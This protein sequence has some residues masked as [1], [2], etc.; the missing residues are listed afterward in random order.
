MS[1]NKP[2]LLISPP[3]MSLMKFLSRSKA[4]I[5]RSANYVEQI[6][7]DSIDQWQNVS[8]ILVWNPTAED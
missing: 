1:Y 3:T 7:L 8:V 4:T 6:E 2:N 5:Q